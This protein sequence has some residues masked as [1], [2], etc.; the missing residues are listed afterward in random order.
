MTFVKRN[1]LIIHYIVYNLKKN[2]LYLIK[3]NTKLVFLLDTI[4]AQYF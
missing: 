4:K 3:S 2:E 1:R